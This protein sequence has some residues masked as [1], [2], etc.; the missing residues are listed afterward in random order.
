MVETFRNALTAL[1][2][3]LGW[4]PNNVTGG[5]ILITALGVFLVGVR[6]GA[7][8]PLRHEQV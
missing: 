6:S 4:A 3:L 1:R 8:R 2:D 7:G 5:V